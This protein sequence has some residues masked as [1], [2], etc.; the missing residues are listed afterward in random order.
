[1]S[2]LTTRWAT[3]AEIA[4]WDALVAE[5]PGGGDFLLASTIAD[6]KTEY[7]MQPRYLVFERSG[8]RISCALVLERRIPFLGRFWSITRAPAVPTVAEFEEH[9]DALRRFVRAHAKGVF[10]V[11]VE[12]PIISTEETE[13]ELAD[14]ASLNAPDLVR[15]EG[16]Q[17]NTHTVLMPVQLDDE[18]LVMSYPKK[19][20]NMVRRAQRDGVVVREFEPTPEVFERMHELMRSVGGGDK[21]GLMLKPKPY[22]EA[23]WKHFS[24]R[25]QGRFFGIESDGKIAVM[26]FVIRIGTRGFYKDGGSERALTT[27]GMSNLLHFEIMRTLRDEGVDVYDMFG[28]AP[29]EATSNADHV[30][31]ASGNFKLTFG[32]RTTFIGA[33]D[34]IVRRQQ[35][36]I[37]Q[38]IGERAFAKVYRTRTGDFS[39]Y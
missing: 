35:Q 26:A 19:T 30:S 23:L 33:F 38:R 27:P 37:W 22:V 18:A 36:R 15:R 11:T 12:P 20:R 32:P 39:I 6:A 2:E 34:L 8:E 10:V 29:P 24:A 16:I 9:M 4:D 17:G 3:D 5:N 1:M 14:S 31:F 7:G 21:E 25:G 28:V 13:Q